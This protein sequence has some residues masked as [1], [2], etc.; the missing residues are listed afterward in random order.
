MIVC[1]FSGNRC[2]CV[3]VLVT[4]LGHF[5]LKIPIWLGYFFFVI[6]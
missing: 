3:C 2:V 5:V 4:E 6:R 1:I